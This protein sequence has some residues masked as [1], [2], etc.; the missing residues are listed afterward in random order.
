[1]NLKGKKLAVLGDSITEGCGVADRRNLFP[2][3]LKREYGL[4]E[5]L[6]FG[7]G[8]TRIARQ[9]CD[10]PD[11][12]AYVDRFVKMPDGMD[13]VAVFGGTNDYGH[14]DAKIGTFADDGP[15]TFYGACRALI[16]GLLTKYPDALVVVMTPLHR[17]GEENPSPGNFLPLSAYVD[18]IK[19]VAAY[20][21]VPVLDLY[22][23][24]GMQPELEPIRKKYCPDG[25][26]PCDSGHYLIASRLGGFLSAL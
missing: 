6:N 2:E 24:S 20:Y 17:C 22:S 1:M 8:G 19:E 4:S 18:I 10:G 23:M 7:I 25:L 14:G 3:I 12:S 26:H 16:S 15:T 5:A 13:I 9:S 21:A 11:S